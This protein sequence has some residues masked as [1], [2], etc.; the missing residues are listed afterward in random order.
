MARKSQ[1]DTLANAF[2]KANSGM[3]LTPEG[4]GRINMDSETLMPSK[5]PASRMGSG[6]PQ[7]PAQHASVEK[8]AKAS[9]MKRRSHVVGIKPIS[10]TGLL[11]GKGKL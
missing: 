4:N 9:V 3:Q 5:A 2:T 1:I 10:G 6:R 7:S 11:G 8:A